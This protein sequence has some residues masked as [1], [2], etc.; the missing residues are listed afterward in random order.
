MKHCIWILS[1]FSLFAQQLE[2]RQLAATGP[3]PSPRF[4]GTIAFNNQDRKLYLFGGTDDSG[5]VNDLWS[6]D[7]AA[8]AWSKLAPTGPLPRPR[9]G[10]TLN[11]DT[12][13]NQLLV[14]AG[15]AGSLFG[16][17]WAFDVAA[18]T[19]RELSATG[20]G[21]SARYGHSVV[22]DS[23]RDRLLLS[24]GFT[25][26][27]GR[28]DDT[29]AFD[30]NTRR[31]SNITP[32]GPKPLR[33]CLHHAVISTA[34]DEMYLYG[35]CSSGAGPCPQGDLWILDL[36]RNQWR[37]VSGA[38][39]PPGRQWYGISFDDARQRL[40][41][42]GGAGNGQLGDAWEFDPAT[43]N[44]SSLDAAGG[45]PSARQRLQ[46]AY[47]DGFGSVF[48]GG[49]VARNTNELWRLGRPEISVRG[50]FDGS[51]GPFAANEIVSVYG[52]SLAESVA[53][54]GQPARVFFASP[55]QV[56]FLI[57]AEL[58]GNRRAQVRVGA[59]AQQIEL[60][61]AAPKFYRGLIRVQDVLVL[62]G[63][64]SGLAP[65][66]ARAQVNGENAELLYAGEAP[67]FVGLSQFNVRIPAAQSTAP[68]FRVRIEIGDASGEVLLAP[69]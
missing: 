60:R 68:D 14:V 62:Y 37:E 5:D 3:Q 9:H 55:G 13:R 57:P 63:T 8:T 69:Q 44:W 49:I 39:K 58:A 20:T 59:L 38:N 50:V 23:K 27:R 66:N 46:G 41:L 32:T 29:W 25:S 31:W 16:D 10:H 33:R 4:D 42:F 43:Q 48:F 26:E 67:G 12:K 40:V 30:L 35:G 51:A 65:Q 54:E 2:W 17:V 1:A 6:Y 53:V 7:F 24:H 56:N 52:V 45:K 11:Y 18:N 36:A 47:A 64:G 22:L 19:W 61:A 34:R 28:F 21:P 15:Q